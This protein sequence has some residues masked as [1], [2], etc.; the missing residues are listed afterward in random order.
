MHERALARAVLADDGMDLALMH[1]DVDTREG[2]HAAEALPNP[3]SRQKGPV[4]LV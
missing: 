2:L 4:R 1:V 3:A